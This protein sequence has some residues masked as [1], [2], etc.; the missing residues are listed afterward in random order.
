MACEYLLEQ[1][2]I[3]LQ[4]LFKAPVLVQLQ[5]GSHKGR[6][7]NPASDSRGRGHMDWQPDCIMDDLGRSKAQS[8]KTAAGQGHHE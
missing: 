8:G 7:R 2:C 6:R 3:G 1:P 5:D 4:L